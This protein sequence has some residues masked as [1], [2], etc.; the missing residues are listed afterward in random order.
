MS[1]FLQL[2]VSFTSFGAGNPFNASNKISVLFVNEL[3]VCTP[4]AKSVLTT[5]VYSQ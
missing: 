2:N 4:T 1:N 3:K 5:V